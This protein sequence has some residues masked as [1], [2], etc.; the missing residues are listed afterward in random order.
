MVYDSFTRSSFGSLTLNQHAGSLKQWNPCRDLMLSPLPKTH[1]KVTNFLDHDP[2]RY[3]RGAPSPLIRVLLRYG[4]WRE[5][6][7][8]NCLQWSMNIYIGN[9]PRQESPRGSCAATSGALRKDGHALRH[10]HPGRVPRMGR[11]ETRGCLDSTGD[12]WYFCF[13]CV[14]AAYRHYQY[15]T[16]SQ[17]FSINPKGCQSGWLEG[18]APR[19]SPRG[20]R[21]CIPSRPPHAKAPIVRTLFCQRLAQPYDCAACRCLRAMQPRLR[22]L[23]P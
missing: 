13:I 3:L 15:H 2:P 14:K 10:V 17:P 6:I 7:C 16:S 21:R 22:S 5:I 9:C 11:G 19:P 23:I 18:Q 1:S 20:I 12:R 4:E 8:N